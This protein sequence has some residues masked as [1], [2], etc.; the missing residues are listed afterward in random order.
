FQ[1]GGVV[2]HFGRQ[3]FQTH[4]AVETCV[5]SLINN[6]HPAPAE[7]FDNA[8]MGDG[9]ADELA[10]VC[11]NAA[12]LGLRRKA[13]QRSDMKRLSMRGGFGEASRVGPGKQRT[14]QFEFSR[15]REKSRSRTSRL[16]SSNPVSGYLPVMP[17]TIRVRHFNE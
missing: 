3:K 16:I 2:E 11:H 6:T 7:S 9:L 4:G 12:I 5:L 13:S 10:G 15:T 8:V 1:S 14:R 17:S